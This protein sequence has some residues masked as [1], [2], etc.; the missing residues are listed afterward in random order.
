[1]A[2]SLTTNF[3]T[4]LA[5]PMASARQAGAIRRRRITPPAGHALEILGHAIEYLTDEMVHQGEEIF[6]KNAHLEAVQLLM[7]VN[8]QVYFECPVVPT[9]SERLRS[10]LRLNTA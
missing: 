4:S 7:H 5:F 10:I 3:S 9:L 1:M 2:S 6:P 8:R